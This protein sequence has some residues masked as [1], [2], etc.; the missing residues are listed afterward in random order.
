MIVERIDKLA[1]INNTTIAA[2]ERECGLARG[3]IGKWNKSIPSAD[4]LFKVAN[5]LKKPMEYFFTDGKYSNDNDETNIKLYGSSLSDEELSLI[6]DYR[7]LDDKNKG[8]IIGRLEALIEEGKIKESKSVYKPSLKHIPIY[9]QTAAGP[10]IDIVEVGGGYY[11]SVPETADA[12]YALIVKGDS[13]SPKIA[14]GDIV[15]IKNVPDM[16]NGTIGVFDIN[17]TVTCKKIHK[18]NNHIELISFNKNYEPIILTPK[19]DLEFRIIGKV[20]FC[21]GKD[22]TFFTV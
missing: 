14:D 16:E 2:I 10:P 5:F 3:T 6:M 21:Q 7:K 8:I 1:K 9:G 18:S 17:G 13:M 19:E 12:D 15:F 4:K 22:G 20:S 11:I